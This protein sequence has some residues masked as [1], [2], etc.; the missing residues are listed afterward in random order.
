LT[1]NDDF[2]VGGGDPVVVAAHLE[3]K[4]RDLTPT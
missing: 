4:T 1:A 2:E 3:I